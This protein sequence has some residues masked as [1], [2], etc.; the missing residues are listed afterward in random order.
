LGEAID[1]ELARRR[2][3]QR[4]AAKQLKVSQQTLSKWR[5]GVHFPSE[6]Y[7]ARLADFLDLTP[8]AI[9]AMRPGGAVKTR[10]A[11][12]SR[13]DE[14]ETAVSRLATRQAALVVTIESLAER[15]EA[16]ERHLDRR[17][18]PAG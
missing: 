7:H 2:I 3:R 1:A 6:H 15:A 11:N 18:R 8:E 9:D 12:T 17:D 13:I 10:R 16:L 4:A 14:L 5:S